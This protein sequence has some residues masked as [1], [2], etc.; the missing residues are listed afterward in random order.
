MQDYSES[1]CDSDEYIEYD[2][3]KIPEVKLFHKFCR[4][5]KDTPVSKIGE[6]SICEKHMLFHVN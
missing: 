2:E 6:K 3:S 4:P 5:L 1:D